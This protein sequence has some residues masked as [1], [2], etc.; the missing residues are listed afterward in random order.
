MARPRRSLLLLVCLLANCADAVDT[1][2]SKYFCQNYY[3][4]DGDDCASLRSSVVANHTRRVPTLELGDPTKSPL[5]FIHGWP[6]SSALWANQ[7]DHFCG[8]AASSEYYCVAL[9]WFDFHPDVPPR[10]TS[11]LLWSVQLEAFHHVV[12]VEMGLR[13]LTL[14]VFDFGAILGYQFAYRW[15]QL[16]K[17]LV[18]M[19]IGMDPCTLEPTLGLEC[20][21]GLPAGTQSFEEQPGYVQTNIEA[22]LTHDDAM[23]RESYAVV[24]TPCAD[25]DALITGGIGWP[26]WQ[27]VRDGPGETWPENVLP[28]VPRAAWRYSFAPSI[29]PGIPI[30]F[31]Y[32]TCQDNTGCR[33]CPPCEERSEYAEYYAPWIEWVDRHGDGFRSVAIDGADHWHMCRASAQTNAAMQRW[34][35]ELD[36]RPAGA[37]R[38]MVRSVAIAAAGVARPMARSVAI[39]AAVVAVGALGAVATMRHLRTTGPGEEWNLL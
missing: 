3:Q 28:R 21:G 18:A 12:A 38:P 29:P 30:L 32:G 6:D 39:A 20:T 37:A 2:L 13:D 26:Y 25:C 31:T 34:F 27:L 36:R 5:V 33:G 4:G 9:S 7:F 1:L 35:E 11:D 23:M 19:D 8:S 16:V 24:G 10:P 17:R 15:P 14:V 22:F